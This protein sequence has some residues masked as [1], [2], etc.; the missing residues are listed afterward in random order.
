MNRGTSKY[1]QVWVILMTCSL[2]GCVEPFNTEFEDFE[3]A[4]V[5]DATIT[6]EMKRQEILLTRTYRLQDDDTPNEVGAR[7]MV[8]DDIGNEFLFEEADFGRYVSNV[9]FAAVPDRD[10]QLYITA[11]NGREYCSTTMQ[12]PQE[13]TLDSLY[14]NRIINDFGEEGM[15]I[16]VNTSNPLGDSNFYRYEYEE[17]Y[18]VIAPRWNKKELEVVDES[19]GTTSIILVPRSLDERVC[20]PKNVS[21]RFI[22]TD[23]DDFDTGTV[24]NFM[25]KFIE[26]N[27]FITIHRYSIL[28]RQFVHSM[29][30]YNF[31]ETL[32]AFSISESLFSETQPGFL[33]GN[34]AAEDNSTEKVLGFFDVA[35]VSEKRIFFGY[36]DFFPTERIPDYIEP[37]IENAPRNGVTDLIR[38]DLIKYIKDNEGEFPNGGPYITVPQVCGDCTI[39]GTSEVPDFW[40]E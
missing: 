36:R 31:L 33:E 38:W 22:L 24:D 37:C 18:K 19:D 11:R 39:L 5:V 30:T 27:N 6:D 3:D 15:G 1:R 26:Q 28:V 34:I 40:I 9:T 21:N 10:Y 16:F 23:T 35:A 32:N 12:L 29:E 25:I 2:M 7:I 17:T 20:Y 13:S 8:K 14:A 4:F